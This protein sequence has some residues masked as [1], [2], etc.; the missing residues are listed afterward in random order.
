MIERVE[1]AAALSTRSAEAIAAG[2]QAVGQDDDIAVLSLTRLG[3][4]E[5]AG[6]PA[7]APILSPA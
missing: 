6:A 3:V 7:A 2:A 4:G 1:R 5:E